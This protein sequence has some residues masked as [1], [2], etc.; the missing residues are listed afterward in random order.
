MGPMELSSVGFFPVPTTFATAR[1]KIMVKFFKLLLL[2]LIVVTVSCSKDDEPAIDPV[3]DFDCTSVTWDTTISFIISNSCAISG[4]HVP[5][6]GRQN[7]LVPATVQF[8]AAG[9]KQRT[10][11][12]TMPQVG[13]LTD[14]Q[15]SQIA[16]WV[17]E[18]ASI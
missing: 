2:G 16:C 18:G 7:F 5:S 3:D 10:G 17:D 1:I 9:I 6:T 8:N 12:R 13:S 4:C 15:I 11:N 14:E